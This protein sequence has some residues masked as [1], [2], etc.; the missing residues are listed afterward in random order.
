MCVWALLSFGLS[1]ILYF[2]N[3]LE[4]SD[5]D[6]EKEHAPDP[7]C[8][9]L[10]GESWLACKTDHRAIKKSEHAKLSSAEGF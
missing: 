9:S 10:S 7:T 6:S 8:L 3:A 5:V 4:T 1:E 2:D